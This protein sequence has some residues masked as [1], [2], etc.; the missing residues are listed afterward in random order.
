MST[1]PPLIDRCLRDQRAA[2]LTWGGPVGGM[3]A[4]MAAL[5]P[6]MEDAI[7]R[8]ME[9]YPKNVLAA[10]GI[11]RIDSLEAWLHT[12]MFSLIVPLT[13]AFF[14]IRSATRMLVGAEER[15]YLD[16]LLATP[17]TR[18]ALV[19]GSFVATLVV[20]VAVLS[21]VGLATLVA[22]ILA[23][24]DPAP[25]VLLGGLAGVF[26]LAAFFAGVAVLLAGVVRGSSHV[27]GIASGLVLAMYLIDFLG[28]VTS[29]IQPLR[30]A[31]AFRYYG[32]PLIDGFDVAT[33]TGLCL[34]GV[35]S[36]S[37]GAILFDRRDLGG[38]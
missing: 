12:E 27:V 34:A 8:I 35:A 15:G 22:G 16:I 11:E 38:R 24:S 10:F 37:L 14:A 30:V 29:T 3:C 1:L 31:S 32:A 20:L 6:S 18:R 33:F 13:L 28:K 36:A 9:V 25:T 4:L 21:V 7:R 5:Y 26:A 23:A 17:L 2:P 19:A